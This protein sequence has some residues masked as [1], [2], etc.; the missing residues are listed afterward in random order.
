MTGRPRRFG[1]QAGGLAGLAGLAQKRQTRS[2]QRMNQWACLSLPSVT[3]SP[4]SLT[5]SL[6]YSS[7]SLSLH[8]FPSLPRQYALFYCFTLA[9][10]EKP[11]LRAPPRPSPLSKIT[12]DPQTTTDVP[13]RSSKPTNHPVAIATDAHLQTHQRITVSKSHQASKDSSLIQ[14]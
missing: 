3:R 11:L 14:Y 13:A 9:K 7:F 5:R 8:S 6:S 10:R 12:G 2:L 1:L 4:H